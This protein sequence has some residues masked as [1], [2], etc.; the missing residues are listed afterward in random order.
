MTQPKSS[1]HFV[2][3]ANGPLPNP[4]QLRPHLRPEAWLICAD[5]GA[6]HAHALGL[7]P[8]L[9]IGDMDSLDP[10]LRAELEAADVPFEVHPVNKNETDLEL[11][12]AWA[13]ERGATAIDVLAVLGGRLDQSLA[14][15]LLLTRPEWASAR[16]RAIAAEEVAWPVRGGERITIPGSVGDRLSLVPL[17][18]QVTGV[19]FEGVKWPL[20]EASLPLGSTWGISN[21]LIAPPAHLEIGEG[22]VLVVHQVSKW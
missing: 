7:T 8:D 13:I 10:A 4:A 21:E 18:P 5:G 9:V 20:R 1:T 16:L 15:L 22:L 6:H 2:I 14:N 3:I 12:L 17:S 11:A 19:T